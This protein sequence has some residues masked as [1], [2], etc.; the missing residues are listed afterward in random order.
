MSNGHT[1]IPQMTAIAR[2]AGGLLLGHFRGHV[3]VE[4]KGEADLVTIADRESEKLIRSRIRQY[5]PTHDILGEEEG[6][7]D[8][9]S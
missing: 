5:W 7:A 9:G 4:Y 6:F 2:E 8:T 1:Y 3:A